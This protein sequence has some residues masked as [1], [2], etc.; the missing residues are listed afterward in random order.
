MIVQCSG[1]LQDVR[2]L[3][4]STRQ[5]RRESR[6]T[7]GGNIDRGLQWTSSPLFCYSQ[8]TVT[9]KSF[10]AAAALAFVSGA[11]AR[12]FTVYN[13]CPFTIWYVAVHTV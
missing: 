7:K 10:T 4:N 5:P 1:L 6:G 8:L 9:M 3:S 11:A 2:A 12:T 13:N